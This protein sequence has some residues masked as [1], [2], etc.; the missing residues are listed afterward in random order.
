MGASKQKEYQGPDT[1]KEK[2]ELEV[3][4]TDYSPN[5]AELLTREEEVPESKKTT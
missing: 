3:S 4:E 1:N 5:C 2:V